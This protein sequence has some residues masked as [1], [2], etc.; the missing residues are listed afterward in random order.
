M[1]DGCCITRAVPSQKWPGT[2]NL[3]VAHVWV[4]RSRWDGQCVLDD[5][6]AS[7]ITAFLAPPGKVT[8]KPHRLKSND[9]KSFQGSIVLGMGFVLEPREAA[10][11]IAKDRRNREVL[12]PYLNGE[13]LNSRPDQSPSRWVIN[14]FDWP[15]EKAKRS[16]QTA[17]QLLRKKSNQIDCQT[18]A[19]SVG[20]SGGSTPKKHPLFTTLSLDWSEF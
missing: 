18:S 19:R 17:S 8:G 5:K 9:G 7:G 11:L 10:S 1:A 16:T 12:F 2:A 6:P 15:I 13:D 20:R 4:R 14:F 3:E